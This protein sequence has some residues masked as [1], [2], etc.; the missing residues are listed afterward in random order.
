MAEDLPD[1]LK[2]KLMK[3]IMSKV[4][5][6]SEEKKQIEK[7]KTDPEKIVW[8]KLSDERAREL[9]SKA[10]VL[11]PDKYPLVI[12]VFYALIQQGKINEFD[13]Y[14]TLL[15]LH[16]LGVPVKPDLRIRFVKHGKEVD[17]KEY[18]G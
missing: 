18:L 12:Q 5:R 10:K 2:M 4:M 3:K 7:E 16:R 11:Y 17:M 9:M 1:H 6:S 8:E 15:L 14:T 13:G